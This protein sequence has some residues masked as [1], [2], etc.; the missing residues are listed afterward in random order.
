MGGK[1]TLLHSVNQSLPL[2][3]HVALPSSVVPSY[4]SVPPIST[5]E[6]AREHLRVSL[7]QQEVADLTPTPKNLV[8]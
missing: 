3:Y 5:W 4:A 2:S 6:G 7:S 8:T 1:K